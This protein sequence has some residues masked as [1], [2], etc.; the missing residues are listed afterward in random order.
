M[1][2]FAHEETPPRPAAAAIVL[3]GDA[4]LLITRNPKLAF[5]G[6]H[7]AFPGGAVEEEDNAVAVRN[8]PD[9]ETARYI[10][11]V[12]RETFEE[13]GLLLARGD[14]PPAGGR[15]G[16]RRALHEDQRTFASILSGFGLH[17]DADDFTGAGLW[18]TPPFSPI[19]F[20]THYLLHHCR[21]EAAPSIFE[22]DS[23][24]VGAEWMGPAEARRRWHT[25]D[26]VKLSTP[27]AFALHHLAALPLERALP[28]MRKTP[29]YDSNAPHWFE[30]RP[31]IHIVAMRTDTLPPATHTNCIL[32]G[33]QEFYAIDPGASDPEQQAGLQRVIEH[34]GV[35]GGRLKGVLL[36][37][38]HGD[39]VSAAPM[40]Q[41]EYGV[42]V[43]AHAAAAESLPFPVDGHID[44]NG[45]FECAGAPP[46]RIRCLHTP[47]HDPGHVAFFEESTGTLLCGDLMAN[48]GT[49]VVA[50][51][52]GGDMTAYL[53]S[54]ERL[55][56]LP[57]RFT[58][59]GHGMPSWNNSGK[60]MLRRLIKHRLDREARIRGAIEAGAD[61]VDAVLET[62]YDDTPR[63]V[64]PLARAQLAAHLVR[65]GVSLR[66][67]NQE[68][69]PS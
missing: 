4:A 55:L 45:V 12:A 54:L 26:G 61:T 40:L 10:A 17:L 42:P 23:E 28:W 8:A 46:W 63:E 7:H 15:A 44:D 52:Y 66:D 49:V 47:G 37:H 69:A 59:P 20:H 5:M 56:E 41:R 1:N 60:D 9:P 29:V 25:G 3:R 62:A 19:R 67:A 13:T 58:V 16:P 35:L 24:V 36:T 38:S 2:W 32:V 22:P 31:G 39:H 57:L 27:V 64:W 21:D 33:E 50:P 30:P 51:E 43:Y 68:S 18:I 11:A 48:P 65:L 53:D 34:L 6:G 14:L